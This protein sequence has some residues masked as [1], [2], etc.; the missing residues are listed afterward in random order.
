M[1]GLWNSAAANQSSQYAYYLNK[2]MICTVNSSYQKYKQVKNA[3]QLKMQTFGMV[4]SKVQNKIIW[5]CNVIIHFCLTLQK[6]QEKNRKSSA[7]IQYF[8][9]HMDITKSQPQSLYNN[10]LIQDKNQWYIC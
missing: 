5:T 7:L 9:S 6:L 1:Y 10:H 3:S 4:H 8:L 2:T